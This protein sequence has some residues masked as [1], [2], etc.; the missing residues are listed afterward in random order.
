MS[1]RG[2]IAEIHDGVESEIPD[3]TFAVPAKD[4]ADD[5]TLSAAVPIFVEVP[6]KTR[7]VSLQLRFKDGTS[8]PIRRYNVPADPSKYY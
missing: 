8:S 5:G 2:A 7:L 3:R 4:D 1:Y 6:T